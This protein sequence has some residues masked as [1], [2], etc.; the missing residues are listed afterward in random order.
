MMMAAPRMD[1]RNSSSSTRAS[2]VPPQLTLGTFIPLMFWTCQ[3]TPM[4]PHTVYA[5][6]CPTER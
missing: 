6:R 2:S 1:R 4:S 3:W 5:T